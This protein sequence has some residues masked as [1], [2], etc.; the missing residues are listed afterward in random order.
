[1]DSNQDRIVSIKTRVRIPVDT[2][3]PIQPTGKFRRVKEDS[4]LFLR[5]DLLATVAT[6]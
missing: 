4:R 3:V 1:M 2:L 6:T 5:E